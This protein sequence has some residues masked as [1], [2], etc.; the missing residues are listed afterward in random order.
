M[1]LLHLPL[2]LLYMSLQAAEEHHHLPDLVAMHPLPLLS[3]APAAQ[4]V[5]CFLLPLVSVERTLQQSSHGPARMQKF[6]LHETNISTVSLAPPDS[7]LLRDLQR[8]YLKLLPQGLCG[9]PAFGQNAVD[10][11][12]HLFVNGLNCC[13]ML[14]WLLISSV[15]LIFALSALLHILLR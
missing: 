10:P 5:V 13:S 9:L 4:S 14:K 12:L 11:A 1:V 3:I 15:R 8:C 2:L 7:Y 6:S